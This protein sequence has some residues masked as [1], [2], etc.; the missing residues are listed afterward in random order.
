MATEAFEGNFAQFHL[1]LGRQPKFASD[2][3][4]T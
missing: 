1:Q 2:Q 3:I 4:R